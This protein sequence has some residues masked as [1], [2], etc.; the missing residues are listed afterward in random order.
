M[1]IRLMQ[2]GVGLTV[3]SGR[4]LYGVYDLAASCGITLP[5]IAYNGAVIYDFGKG[6]AERT[7]SIQPAD[8]QGLF[9]RFD[10]QKIPYKTC[11]FRPQE[12]RCV[13]YLQNRYRSPNWSE[14]KKRIEQGCEDAVHPQN[15][16]VY[17]EPFVDV[18]LSQLLEGECLYIG[19]S[20]EQQ[21]ITAIYE[22]AK[23]MPGVSAVLHCSPYDSRRWFVDIGSDQAGKGK[24]AVAL[25]QMLSAQQ[26]VTFGDNHND[27]PMLLAADRS[28]VVPQAPQ[29]ARQAA[30]AVLEEDVD[31]VLQFIWKE[32]RADKT[33]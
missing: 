27:I 14:R 15:G 28:Y 22:Q 5:V 9:E 24:A 4:N 13:T 23:Q 1:F 21:A 33:K 20:G 16:L 30:T 6:K 10:R 32:Y 19:S 25:K 8:A 7:F 11:V 29:E 3:A 12:E 17:D 2:E 26:L 31:C 18:P